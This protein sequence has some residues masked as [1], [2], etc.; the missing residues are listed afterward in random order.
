M[1]VVCLLWL[2]LLCLELPR[3]IQLCL[4]GFC[5]LFHVQP[6]GGNRLIEDVEMMVGKRNY[7]FWLWWKACWYF[8]S[9]GI[10]V[11]SQASR[12][13]SVCIN[14]HVGFWALFR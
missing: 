13:D 2:A 6:A 12:L 4:W 8:I 9:P 5:P 1:C 14:V 3:A 10:L 7:V 11:V